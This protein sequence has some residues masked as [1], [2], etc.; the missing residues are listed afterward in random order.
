MKEYLKALKY[1]LDNGKI[2]T[3]RTGTNTVSVFGYQ[4]R[5]NLQDGFP[6][7]TTRKL[8][9]KSMVSELLWF[10]EG[11]SDERRLAEILHS[12]RD[13]LYKTIWTENA[14]ADYWIDRANYPG[15][16]G[17]IYGKQ[18][19]DWRNSSGESIDQIQNLING[20]KTDPNSRRHIIMNYNPGEL[21]QMCLP[22]C[23]VLSQ[24][25]VTDGKLSCQLYQRSADLP[26]GSPFNIASYSLLTH[27][28]AQVC[29]LDVG[30]FIYSIGDMHIYE[31]QIEHA[32]IQLSREPFTPPKLWLNPEIKDINQFGMSD[33]QLQNYNYHSPINYPFTV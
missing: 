25:D 12:S 33:I 21:D 20:V 29:D 13:S 17:R 2:K 23:H 32:N 4:M 22:P 6:A 9:F 18:M 10:L 19:R 3:N 8:P 30:E 24:F 11:S 31:N 7:I 16:C 27:M 5:F 28:I 26:L 14:Y 15:D 1:I